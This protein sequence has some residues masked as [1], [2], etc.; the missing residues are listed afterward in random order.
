MTVDMIAEFGELHHFLLVTPINN[1][2]IPSPGTFVFR[3]VPEKGPLTC[4]CVCVC[5]VCVCVYV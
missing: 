4:V 1:L 2:H 5:G 3:V